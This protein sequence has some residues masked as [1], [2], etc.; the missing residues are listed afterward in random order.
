MTHTIEQKY[1][2]RFHTKYTKQAN[3]CWEWD[4]G[5]NNYGYGRYRYPNKGTYAHRFSYTV[6]NGVIPPNMQVC[7]TCDNPKCV[8]PQHLWL[9]TQND[10]MQD[11]KQKHRQ[12]HPRGELNSS[13]VLTEIDV[14]FI[15]A[16][17]EPARS[18]AVRYGVDRG[19]IYDIRCRRTWRHI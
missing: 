3:G 13:A 7:H 4:Y 8:N 15:R 9:G 12:N 10:N 14:H 17:R 1:I 19:T 16:A 11:K 6:H 2:D 18:L 5:T